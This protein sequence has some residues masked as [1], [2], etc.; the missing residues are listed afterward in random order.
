MRTSCYVTHSLR[1]SVTW[2]RTKFRATPCTRTGAFTKA[3][4]KDAL[5]V[6]DI[7]KW[8]ARME[9]CLDYAVRMKSDDKRMTQR[10]EAM[11]W[12]YNVWVREALVGFAECDYKNFPKA[13]TD[14]L[15][16]VARSFGYS[17]PIER[18]HS[19]VV[20]AQRQSK[21][22]ALSRIGKMHRVMTSGILEN[23]DRVQPI[24]I[25]EN[26][27]ASKVKKI[28][29]AKMFE[30]EKCEFSLDVDALEI[31]KENKNFKASGLS[32]YF[33]SVVA[34]SGFIERNANIEQMSTH[35]LSMLAIPGS[36]LCNKKDALGLT[37]GYVLS[38]SEF[39]VT[40]WNVTPKVCDGQR[41]L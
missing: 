39:G 4:S 36:L 14:D 31:L 19:V 8:T 40:V 3:L 33:A 1:L 16:D 5:D 9:K 13:I 20:D 35:F 17:V 27:Q 10:L 12:P 30:A 2:Q 6:G 37:L 38:S 29:P 25:F 15:T 22:G 21:S 28:D 41:Y 11:L 34:T 26:R 7:Y 24:P 23:C 18:M 32:G